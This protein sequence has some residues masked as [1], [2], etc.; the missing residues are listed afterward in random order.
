LPLPIGKSR[1]LFLKYKKDLKLACKKVEA[2]YFYDFA[3]E[4]KIYVSF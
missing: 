1:A 3:K 4:I 2:K